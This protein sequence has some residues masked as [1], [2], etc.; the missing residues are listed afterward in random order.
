M[1]GGPL[2]VCQR[3]VITWP[4]VT[5]MR[6]VR[7]RFVHVLAVLTLAAPASA[8]APAD[9]PQALFDRAIDDFRSGRLAESVAAFDML[10]QLLPDRAPGLWQRGIT[11]YYAG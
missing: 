10:A 8:Q 9:R 2:G 4:R 3:V 5:T 1:S 11:L 7:S 6:T